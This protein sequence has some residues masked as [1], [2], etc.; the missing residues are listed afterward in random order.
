M[1]AKVY[2]VITDRILEKLRQGE[3]P[4]RGRPRWDKNEPVVFPANLSTMK[5]YRGVNWIQLVA[6]DFLSPYWLTFKQIQAMGGVLN[7]GAKSAP[8]LYYHFLDEDEKED[9]DDKFWVRYYKVFNL[10]DIDGI[11]VPEPAREKQPIKACQRLLRNMPSNMPRIKVGGNEAA[12]VH[13]T[14]TITMPTKRQFDTPE[15]YYATL[16]HE[17]AHSTGHRTRLC[18]PRSMDAEQYAFEELVAEITAAFLCAHCDIDNVVLDDAAAYVK[19]YL[20]TLE[21]DPR[22]IIR[23]ASQAQKAADY[24]LNKKPAKKKSAA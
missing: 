6:Q 16:F 22:M 20:K 19:F 21:N 1:S 2:K 12:Y 9:P 11:E 15:M 3:I 10:D 4:W 14:D 8:V 13:R 18:R 7:K 5:T 17:L 23:A 24:I